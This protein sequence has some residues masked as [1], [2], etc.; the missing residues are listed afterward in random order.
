MNKSFSVVNKEFHNLFTKT[1]GTKRQ[2]VNYYFEKVTSE[3][4][5]NKTLYFTNKVAQ[6][7]FTSQQQYGMSLRV[8][9]FYQPEGSPLFPLK[10]IVRINDIRS[11]DDGRTDVELKQGAS[12]AYVPLERFVQSQDGELLFRKIEPEERNIRSPRETLIPGDKVEVK[13]GE[14]PVWMIYAEEDAS[15]VEDSHREATLRFAV[16]ADNGKYVLW[17]CRNVN[18]NEGYLQPATYEQ[19]TI[20]PGTE[21]HDRISRLTKEYFAIVVKYPSFVGSLGAPYD[22]GMHFEAK[23][24]Y[25]PSERLLVTRGKSPAGLISGSIYEMYQVVKGEQAAAIFKKFTGGGFSDFSLKRGKVE[26]QPLLVDQEFI[27]WANA[28]HVAKNPSDKMQKMLSGGTGL[29]KLLPGVQSV[30]V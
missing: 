30:G 20:E 14:E 28:I 1:K 2:L 29:E 6:E 15:S 27:D 24:V 18:V 12:T 17:N 22:R 3:S 5:L 21:D 7:T 8:G 4:F 13:V 16:P 26:Q 9:D 23:A 19:T 25:V 10:G 11:W